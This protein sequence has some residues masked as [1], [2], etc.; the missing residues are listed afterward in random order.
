MG[1]FKIPYQLNLPPDK[2]HVT[3]HFNRVDKRYPKSVKFRYYLENFDKTWSQPSSL[4][5]ATYGNLPPGDYVF[6]VMATN[7][8]G[9]WSGA[10]VAYAFT[11][12]RPFYKAPSFI[13]GSH[14][15]GGGHCHA[16]AAISRV[17]RRVNRVMMLERIRMKEQENLRKEI[18]RDFHDE[19]GNQLTRIINYISLLKLNGMD[20]KQ[21]HEQSERSLY[22]GGRF[23]QVPV[24]RNARF[25]LVHRSGQRRALEAV[26]A[27]T[28]LW[29]E[30]VR[31]KEHQ[32]S[33]L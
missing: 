27:H 10:R 14:Y 7:N 5:Q 19:M 30:A 17:K 21:Q 25:Y 15:T 28:R 6:R 31:G 9:S 3:F 33:R 20:K 11:V 1:F 4:S 2:N 23:C 22:Q 29:R 16:G 18:A 26:P 8:R 12:L 13:A 24:Y 32:L